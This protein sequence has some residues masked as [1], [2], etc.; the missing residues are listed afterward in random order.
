MIIVLDHVDQQEVDAEFNKLVLD[1]EDLET[2]E[3]PDFWSGFA[4]VL[5][6]V[7]AGLIVVGVFT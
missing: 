6:G 1:I 5:V 3:A 7:G 2:L 4:G